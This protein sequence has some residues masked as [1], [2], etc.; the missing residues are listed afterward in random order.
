[1]MYAES[2]GCVSMAGQVVRMAYTTY[3]SKKILFVI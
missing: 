1:M 3:V 2:L